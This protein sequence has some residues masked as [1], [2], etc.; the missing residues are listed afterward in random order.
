MSCCK[1]PGYA[2]PMV[3]SRR[4]PSLYTILV[5]LAHAN[6]ACW[7]PE[8]M[9]WQHVLARSMFDSALGPLDMSQTRQ[10]CLLKILNFQKHGARCSPLHCLT[11]KVHN[12]ESASTCV[13][14]SFGCLHNHPEGLQCLILL[15]SAGGYEGSKR[16]SR[17]S[18]SD[19]CR[20]VNALTISCLHP[21]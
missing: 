7:R 4:D 9:I 21:K 19:L 2:T 13:A 5:L 8:S 18:P 12:L 3:R 11:S 20:S 10:R 17:L 6:E 14:L 15:F 16:A 1:G